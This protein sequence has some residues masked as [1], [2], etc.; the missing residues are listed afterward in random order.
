[1]CILARPGRDSRGA[2]NAPGNMFSSPSL[3]C[4]PLLNCMTPDVAPCE[5]LVHA[6]VCAVFPGRNHQLL[7]GPEEG[8]AQ[9]KPYAGPVANNAGSAGWP[10]PGFSRLR[11]WRWGMVSTIASRQ[12]GPRLSD[13][14]GRKLREFEMP[15]PIFTN[16]ERTEWASGIYNN[17]HTDLEMRTDL[18]KLIRPRPRPRDGRRRGQLASFLRDILVGLNYAYYDRQ[19]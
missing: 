12:R 10:A 9:A 1:M 8:C 5:K 2:L 14:A 17:K 19:G 15:R 13:L 18:A 16:R 3:V 11:C 4:A 7:A 6:A